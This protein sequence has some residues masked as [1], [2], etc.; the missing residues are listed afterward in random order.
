VAF[1]CLAGLI[2]FFTTVYNLA[3]RNVNGK[4]IAV[5]AALGGATVVLVVRSLIWLLLR[6]MGDG[7]ASY[8]IPG[9][10]AGTPLL[11]SEPEPMRLGE[12]SPSMSSVTEHTTRSFDK[13]RDRDQGVR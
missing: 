8:T 12:D 5:V 13:I 9:R 1:V 11:S 2:G 6:M 7:Q 4:T 3:E 10:T